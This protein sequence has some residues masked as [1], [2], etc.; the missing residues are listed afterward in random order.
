MNPME[1]KVTEMEERTVRLFE[2]D[3]YR[4]SF[5]G[6]IV[7]V[8]GNEIA[9]NQ[10][11]FYPEGGGQKGDTGK[12]LVNGQNIVVTDT[13]S[14]RDHPSRIWHRCEDFDTAI[15]NG[16]SIEGQ[17]DWD[18]RYA[19]MKMHTCLHL[20]CSLLPAEV[21]GCGISEEKGRLDLD[22]P[23]STTD[24]SELTE[25]LNKLI[26]ADYPV[27]QYKITENIESTIATRVRTAS[28]LP[29]VIDGGLSMVEIEGVD[30]QPCGGTHVSRVTEI[31][32]VVCRKIE[33][34]S[35]HNRRFTI[36]F[37]GTP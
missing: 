12:L 22:M 13:F 35:R 1:G 27:R 36:V 10:T 4:Q 9:L 33:K 5:E 29:P 7:D 37:A 28:V 2:D 11:C 31:G 6:D 34:K 20:L 17:I 26:A 30:L 23:E 24:K 14:D 3:A 19:H 32:E 25:A 21:T 16:M 18:R 8:R 15:Q